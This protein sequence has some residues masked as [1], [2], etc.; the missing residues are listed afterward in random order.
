MRIVRP[1]LF[2]VVFYILGILLAN[3]WGLVGVIRHPAD[4]LPDDFFAFLLFEVFA[5]LLWPVQIFGDFMAG[6]AAHKVCDVAI[7]FV[8][9]ALSYYI[10]RAI[11]K[12]YVAPKC[13]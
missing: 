4:F 13:A 12:K 2:V 8:F 11:L 1:I 6:G 10:T 5:A 3:A 7:I 9:I